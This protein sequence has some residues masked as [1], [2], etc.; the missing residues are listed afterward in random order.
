[1]A[2]IASIISG[3]RFGRAELFN[4]IEGLSERELTQISMGD[5]WTVKDVLAHVIGWDKRVIKILPLILQN[6]VDEIPTVDEDDYNRQSV[7]A[8][9]G[10]SLAQVQAEIEATQQQIIDIISRLDHVEIDMR[11]EWQGRTITIRSYVIDTMTEHDRK[12]AAGII[13]WRKGLGQQ[14]DPAA[15]R[16]DL[17]QRSADFMNRLDELDDTDLVDKT[18]VGVWSIVDMV[19]HLADWEELMLRAAYH[20]YDPSRPAATPASGDTNEQNRL[21]VATRAG[22]SWPETYH[23]LRETQR[24]T[25][26]FV[27]QLKPGDWKLR[28]PYPWPNDQ[29]TLAELVIHIIE[30]YD[31]HQPDLEQ[32][33]AEQRSKRTAAPQ[34]PWLRWLFDNEATGLAKKEYEAAIKRAGRIWNIVRVMSLNPK[35][36]Q[37]SMRLYSA[38]VHCTSDR[39]GRPEREMIAVVVSQANHCHY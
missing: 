24:A 8:W 16:A 37:A 11:H 18:A 9:R 2:S 34:K 13:E 32:W 12:H 21:M 19:G 1:M 29:G 5:D 10:K 26:D 20:I 15:I 22:K 38:V 14:L 7:G 33:Q 6:R 35:A 27:A 30:H 3:L 4:S 25:A 23:Y 17:L 36:M 31:D 39:L 28:G